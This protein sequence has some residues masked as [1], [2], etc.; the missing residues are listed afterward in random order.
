[1]PKDIP[2]DPTAPRVP[3]DLEPGSVWISIQ[4]TAESHSERPWLI[5]SFYFDSDA[6]QEARWM[7]SRDYWRDGQHVAKLPETAGA[8]LVNDQ[9]I[10]AAQYKADPLVF[11]NGSRSRY[12]F[13]C[14]VCGLSI[15]RRADVVFDRFDKLASAGVSEISL[16]HLAAILR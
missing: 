11:D 16:E 6:P 10:T 5:A 8:R 4:C 14:E 9:V 12:S 3:Y 1:M 2:R 13:K 15:A 7:S